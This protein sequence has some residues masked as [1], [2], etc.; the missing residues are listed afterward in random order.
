MLSKFT[1]GDH[2]SERNKSDKVSKSA[3]LRIGK[4]SVRH[5]EQERKG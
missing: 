3:S 2:D 1:K 5:L 4:T